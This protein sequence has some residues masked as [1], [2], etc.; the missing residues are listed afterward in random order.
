MA[1]SIDISLE[2]ADLNLENNPIP[3]VN[4]NSQSLEEQKSEVSRP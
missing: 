2:N 3:P 1:A 4:M